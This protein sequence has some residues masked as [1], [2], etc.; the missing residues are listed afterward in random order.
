MNGAVGTGIKVFSC[1]L[2]LCL[3]GYV[4][5]PYVRASGYGE[6]A[7]GI[8]IYFITDASF[9]CDN[10][11]YDNP[12]QVGQTFFGVY[13]SLSLAY[14][15]PNFDLSLGAFLQRNFG[16][17]EE[18]SKALPLFRFRYRRPHFRLLAGHLD[19]GYNH[20]LPEALLAQEYPFVYPV[21]EGLQVLA[22]YE[23][24]K[25]DAW[26]NW[27][28]LNTPEHREF[29]AAGVHA[30]AVWTH[31]AVDLGF[32]VSHHGGQLYDAGPVTDNFSGMLRFVLSDEW[33]ALDA[34]IGVTGTLLGSVDNPDRETSGERTQG[35]GG[36]GEVF[37]SPK[38]WKIY[39]RIFSGHDFLVEQGEPIYRTQK[40][41]HRFGVRKTFH[42]DKQVRARFQVE[43]LIIDSSLEY[44]YLL[45]IDVFLNILLHRF[46]GSAS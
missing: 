15:K 4:S 18:V 2:L 11:E 35:F 31:L 3:L 23:N 34:E 38:G 1:L 28:L 7:G 6:A 17:E 19:S 40:P 37:I 29:F 13:A 36:E 10:L 42:L 27:Y 46:P 45:V 16:D 8:P 44:N 20:G 26:I 39:Y 25:A 21:E 5:V 33:P 9:Y 30:E 43:G 24:L 22:Q 14:V 32:R 12:Y 41:L